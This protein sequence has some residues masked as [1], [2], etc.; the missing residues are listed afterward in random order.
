MKLS[1]QTILVLG[2]VQCI[3]LTLLLVLFMRYQDSLTSGGGA[4]LA[5][6]GA[7]VCV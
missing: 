2:I 5:V 3:I 6:P 4:L 1:T 7:A